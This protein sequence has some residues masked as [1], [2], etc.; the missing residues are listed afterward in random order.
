M[1]AFAGSIS[2]PRGT[3]PRAQYLASMGRFL[4]LAGAA[5]LL[6]AAPLGP[7]DGRASAA[8]P[9]LRFASLES[10]RVLAQHETE[11]SDAVAAEVLLEEVGKAP[12]SPIRPPTY[13]LPGGASV[14]LVF[15]KAVGG[16]KDPVFCAAVSWDRHWQQR[17][18]IQDLEK[19]EG[20]QEEAAKLRE[21]LARRESSEVATGDCVDGTGIATPNLLDVLSVTSNPEKPDETIVRVAL[22]GVE[23]L[24]PLWCSARIALGV[25]ERK[26]DGTYVI[27]E[28]FSRVEYLSNYTLV[29]IIVVT[30]TAVVY[31]GT[32]LIMARWRVRRQWRLRRDEIKAMTAPDAALQA[33]LTDLKD[34]LSGRGGWLFDGGWRW[35]GPVALTATRSGRSSLSN[36]Q[37]MFFSLLIFAIV[38]FVLLRLGTLAELSADILLLLG[39]SAG[40]AAGARVTERGRS[41]LSF[42]NYAWLRNKEWTEE[43]ISVPSWAALFTNDEA[44]DISKFQL[45]VFSLIVGVALASLGVSAL[46]TFKIPESMLGILGLSQAVYVAGKAVTP[47]SVSDYGKQID[48]LRLAEDEFRKAVAAAVSEGV[49][50]PADVDGARILALEAYADYIG[51]ARIAAFMHQQVFDQKVP[52]EKLQPDY[53]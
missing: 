50:L 31:L 1:Q 12:P 8:G 35:L 40:G 38:L 46:E 29:M 28:G 43:R 11:V 25:F 51:K 36:L 14:D 4:R 24:R 44:F 16:W 41:R 34:R 26:N 33:E 20:S 19:R 52:E 39:I 10:C 32:A 30:V 7:Y 23:G 27:A 45:A 53:S 6:L 22:P 5:A 17:K 49:T 9:P 37:V 47:P 13:V 21:I 18:K 3:A 48:K 2:R 15:K 42:E